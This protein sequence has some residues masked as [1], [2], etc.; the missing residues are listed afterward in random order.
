MTIRAVTYG[1]GMAKQMESNMKSGLYDKHGVEI[2]VGDKIQIHMPRRLF[3]THY[4]ENIPR[5]DGRYD[6]PLEPAI[7]TITA[8]VKWGYGMFYI[9]HA[10][11]YGDR[12]SS[13]PFPLYWEMADYTS[14]EELIDAF[15]CRPGWWDDNGEGDLDYLLEQYPPNSEQELMEYLSGCE[16][17]S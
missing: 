6:E 14:R 15:Q 17:V 3:Q 1:C 5:P 7:E 4:G 13:E 2:K 16:I 12:C 10:E 9:D 11:I 8:E